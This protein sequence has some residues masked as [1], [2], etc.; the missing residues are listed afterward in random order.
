MSKVPVVIPTL[1]NIKLS[2]TSEIIDKKYI[3]LW[4]HQIYFDLKVI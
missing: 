2:N 3:T 4:L 1:I